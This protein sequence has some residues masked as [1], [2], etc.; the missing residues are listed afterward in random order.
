MVVTVFAGAPDPRTPLTAWDA[1]CGFT[2]TE[3]VIPTRRAEDAAALSLIGCVPI[4]LD[5]LDDQYSAHT[6]LADVAQRL[7][8]V[9]TAGGATSLVG[10]LGLF[11]VD[12]QLTHAACRALLNDRD[13]LFYA[14]VP[15]RSFRRE[16]V[17]ERLI[18]L[19]S[20]GIVEPLTPSEIDATKRA[21]VACYASQ[22]RGLCAEGGPGIE[23]AWESEELF[24]IATSA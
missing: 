10:P 15:Y 11:H 1:A 24:H 7:D 18:T 5:F 2:S 19:Q 14:D 4:W 22:L 23:N 8:E 9:V 6:A 16:E 17:A 13:W 12:H 20:R 3:E 21:A